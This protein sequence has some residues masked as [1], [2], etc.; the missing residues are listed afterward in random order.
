MSWQIFT[1]IAN[2]I[3]PNRL[4]KL[5]RQQILAKYGDPDSNYQKKYCILWEIQQDFAWF[6]AKEIFINKDFKDE[7]FAAFTQL[8]AEGLHVEIKTFDGCLVVR[9]TRGSMLISLHSWGMAIDLNASMEKLGQLTTNWSPRFLEI[10][11]MYVYCGADFISRKD[12]M[13]FS[14]YGE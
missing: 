6:P 4:A 9:N 2:A 5:S 3:N 11:R 8:Q 12:N 14:L 7:L 13:H 10:M 1:R